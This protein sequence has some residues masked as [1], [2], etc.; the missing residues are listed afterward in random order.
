M[1]RH[2]Y[3][4]E[5]YYTFSYSP[6]PNDE[7]GTGGIFCANTDDTERIIGERQL[8]LLRELAA[9]TADARTIEDA[10]TRSARSLA[11]NPRDLPFALIYLVDA[12][13]RA[14]GAGRRVRHHTRVTLPRRRRSP[15]RGVGLWPFAEVLQ[16]NAPCLVVDLGTACGRCPPG[17]WRSAAGAGG[18]LPIAPS[19]Q[20]GQVGRADSRLESVSVCSTMVI[21]DFSTLVAGQIAAAIANAQAYEDGAAGARNRWRS[22]IAPRPLSSRMSRHEFRTPLTLHARARSRTFWRGPAR[23]VD[24]AATSAGGRGSSQRPAAAEAGEHAARLLAHRGRAG[25]GQLPADRSR[26]AHVGP[27]LRASA[28]PS[29]RPACASSSIARRCRSRSTSIATCGRRSFSTCVSN[30][31]KYTFEGEIAVELGAAAGRRRGRAVA[32]ATPARHRGRGDAAA[33]RALPPGGGGARAARTRAPGSAW[34]WCRNWSKLHGGSVSAWRASGAGEYL[35]GAHAVWRGALP[36][37]PASGPRG[38]WSSTATRAEAL[39]RRGGALAAGDGSAAHGWPPRTADAARDSAASHPARRRQ[40]RY[41]G[42]RAPPAR[43]AGYE[44]T[45]VANGQD[46]LRWAARGIRRTWYSATS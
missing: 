33:V 37:G 6:V 29:R 41:A 8:A 5:T 15:G 36:R 35:H 34:R 20:T 13:R 25:A 12:G 45:P 43:S 16:A 26:R 28:P 31:F 11:T 4:E 3:P 14:H 44:V 9:G 39:R 10:C 42:V 24:A 19:G 32:C 1:E 22:W 21:R 27:G 17:A 46:A 40:R 18:A 23:E 30:A 7:G 38:R 2:G